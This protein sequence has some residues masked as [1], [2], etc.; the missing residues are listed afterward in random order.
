MT[1]KWERPKR[2][3]KNWIWKKKPEGGKLIKKQREQIKFL[4]GSSTIG[5]VD[6]K[7]PM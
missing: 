5:T 6:K 2:S 4:Y 7:T 3:N 1:E